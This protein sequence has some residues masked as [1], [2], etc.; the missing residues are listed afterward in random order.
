MTLLDLHV[1]LIDQ[2][3]LF[4]GLTKIVR[5]YLKEMPKGGSVPIELP[6]K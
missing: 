3:P 1:V 6:S 4:Y 2:A 5:S